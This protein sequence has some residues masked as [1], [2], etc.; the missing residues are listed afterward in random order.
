MIRRAET[1]DIPRLVEL[2][3]QMHGE[4][5]FARR[6]IGL[7]TKAVRSFI[8]AGIRRHDGKSEGAS[9][10]NVAVFRGRVEGLMLG[11]LQPVYM[12][13]HGLEAF[14]FWLYTTRRAPKLAASRLI[15]EYLAWALA[16]PRVCDVMLSW[17]DVVG[18][19]ARKIAKLYE[20]KGFRRRGEF[21]V[22]AVR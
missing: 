17:T 7:D 3:A 12:V 8:L 10:F 20:R 5:E 22:R 9:L 1:S 11:M 2:V 16:N 6:G 15:D 4:S 13:C 18:V 21:F 19:D 14:D